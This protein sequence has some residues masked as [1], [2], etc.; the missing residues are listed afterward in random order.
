MA[1]DVFQIM[2]YGHFKEANM[3]PDKPILLDNV[4]PEVFK[5]AMR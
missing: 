3:G 2:F 5:C 1:S 4:D